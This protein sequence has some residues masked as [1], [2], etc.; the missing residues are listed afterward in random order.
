MELLEKWNFS[1][2]EDAFAGNFWGLEAGFYI[3][4][5]PVGQRV[6]L[7]KSMSLG[8]DGL[9][10]VGF[11]NETSEGWELQLNIVGVFN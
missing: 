11:I 6:S 10:G 7:L 5:S 2:T 8:K 3:Y 1:K 4:L 9:A